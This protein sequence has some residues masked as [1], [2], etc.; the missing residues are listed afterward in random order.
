MLRKVSLLTGSI[1][2]V[3]FCLPGYGQDTPS[4]SLGELA[5]QVQAQKDKNHTASAKVITNDDLPSSSGLASLGLGDMGGSKSGSKPGTVESAN[6]SLDRVESFL[7][8]LDSMDRPTLAKTILEGVDH[9]FPGRTHWEEK[10]FAAKGVYVSRLRQLI[11]S[12]RQLKDSAQSLQGNTSPDDPRVKD[13]QNKL[14][15]IIEDSVRTG[16]TFQAV[17]LEGRDLATQSSSH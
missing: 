7:S 13:L 15:L 5:R 12:A 14:R 3:L 9:D 6:E 1:L 2:A 17:V 16:A 4:S 11:Q 8:K 10:L